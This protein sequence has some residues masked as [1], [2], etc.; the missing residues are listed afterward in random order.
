MCE[1]SNIQEIAA[2][3]PDYMGFIF[4]E[5]SPRFV[6]QHFEMPSLPSSIKR[7]GVFVNASTEQ[8]IEKATKFRLDYIQ[9]HGNEPTKQL[10]EISGSDVKII[11]V[12]SVDDQFDFGVTR[13][14][15]PYSDYFLFDTKGKYYGGNAKKFNWEILRRYDQE[16]PFLLSG[17]IGP[18]DLEGLSGMK[19][20]NIHA[21]DVNSGVEVKAGWKDQAKVNEV[22][23]ILNARD[24]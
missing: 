23:R 20:F 22:K 10:E 11:K 5:P 3:E 9:L 17:G 13:A 6:G 1:E 2:V 14:Y 12:F 24:L 8:M 15:A 18:Q 4:F 19:T 16:I 7:V 21:V